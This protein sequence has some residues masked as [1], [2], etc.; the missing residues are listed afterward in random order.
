MRGG[1]KEGTKENNG[2]KSM[3]GY[4]RKIK[5]SMQQLKRTQW[6]GRL[7]G[8][9]TTAARTRATGPDATMQTSQ[10]VQLGPNLH[11]GSSRIC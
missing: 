8:M 10:H 1:I 3:E 11:Y 2:V 5:M 9:Q 6:G 4:Q 7:Q